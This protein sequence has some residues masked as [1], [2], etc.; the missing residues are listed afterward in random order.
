MQIQMPVKDKQAT[1]NRDRQVQQ[2][3]SEPSSRILWQRA[4]TAVAAA[5]GLCIGVVKGKILDEHKKWPFKLS[6]NATH[7][8][9]RRPHEV[10]CRLGESNQC[11]VSLSMMPSALLPLQVVHLRIET[12]TASIVEIHQL[13]R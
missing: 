13:S 9:G 3:A 10:P 8:V 4:L 11:V 7:V 12:V 2:M 1:R 5:H 6:L